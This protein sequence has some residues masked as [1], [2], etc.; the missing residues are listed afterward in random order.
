VESLKLKSEDH[1]EISVREK[2]ERNMANK[3]VLELIAE[4]FKI[5]ASAVL[6]ISDNLINGQSVFDS[7]H[8]KNRN[9][10]R[11]VLR[12]L[13]LACTKILLD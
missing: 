10:R 9:L 5:P 6:M 7:A 12:D 13:F 8:K 2:P 4:Y 3:R 11:Q 1:F